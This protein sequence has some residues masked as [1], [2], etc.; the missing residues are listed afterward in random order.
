MVPPI[1][2]RLL[3]ARRHVG[4]L[5][6]PLDGH[7]NLLT[8]QL[9][10]VEHREVAH[11]PERVCDHTQRMFT[12][13]FDQLKEHKLVRLRFIERGPLWCVWYQERGQLSVVGDALVQH[14]PCAPSIR[15]AVIYEYT[16]NGLGVSIFRGAFDG[17]RMD[18]VAHQHFI[19]CWIKRIRVHVA[20]GKRPRRIITILWF[21]R[22]HGIY[23]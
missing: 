4:R 1:G 20:V 14:P 13:P 6:E 9:V 15:F 5:G 10:A 11:F 22:C 17:P 3:I 2:T 8:E 21:E 19:A 12:C 23:P 7:V 18:G 16:R